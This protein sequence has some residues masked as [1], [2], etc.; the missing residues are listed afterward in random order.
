MGDVK[1]SSPPNYL[2]DFVLLEQGAEGKVLTGTFSG[3]PALAKVRFSKKY[4]HPKIDADIR[5]ERTRAEVRSLVRCQQIP[6]VSVPALYFV[7]SEESVIVMEYLTGTVRCRDYI[8]ELLESN[9]EEILNSL[10]REIGSLIAKI[11]RCNIIHGDLTT[12]NILVK[13]VAGETF[14]FR[15]YLIDFGLGYA[16]GSKAED[17]GVD[18]YVLERALLSTHPKIEDNFSILLEGYKN[19]FMGGQIDDSSNNKNKKRKTNVDDILKKYEEIR[20]RGRK[21]C[22]EG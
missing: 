6:G 12:S 2:K 20:L 5:N 14:P 9:S 10:M 13:K 22:M 18:L 16:E 19:E 4:R 1:S 3:L 17:K 11:H 8:E 15:L 7:D 21:R